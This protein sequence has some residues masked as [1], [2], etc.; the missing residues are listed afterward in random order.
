M[1]ADIEK[2]VT[3]G[4]IKA[5]HTLKSKLGLCDEY[6]RCM[7]SQYGAGSSK[8]LTFE[9]AEGLLAALQQMAEEAGV[10]RARNPKG[11]KY[12]DLEAKGKRDPDMATPRQ[13]RMIEGVWADVSY[14]GNARDRAKALRAFIERRFAVSDLRFVTKAT[15]SR[16][17]KALETML[18]SKIKKEGQKWRV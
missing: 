12:D 9:E 8:D 13:L 4:Q 3:K 1:N 15:A 10:G 17:I 7:L 6:Y 16:I 18:S 5:I 2:T 14:M 11:K